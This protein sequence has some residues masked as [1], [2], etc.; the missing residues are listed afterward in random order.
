MARAKIWMEEKY[1][2]YPIQTFPDGCREEILSAIIKIFRYMW[3]FCGRRLLVCHLTV[4]LPERFDENGTDIIRSALHSWRSA[5]KHRK[6]RG[7]YIWCREE[8]IASAHAR[9]H[10]HVFVIVAGKYIRSGY[11]ICNDLNRLL[12]NRTGEDSKKVHI[13]PPAEDGVR[14]GKKVSE[15][16]NNLEDAIH[17][18][19]Y[20]AK[21]ST[22][23]APY[24]QRTYDYSRGFRNH[25]A[26]IMSCS[27]QE[28]KLFD[29]LDVVIPEEDWDVWGPGNCDLE[30][31]LNFDPRTGGPFY[32]ELKETPSLA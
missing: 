27:S 30:K 19:S 7:E 13:N 23:S 25:P 4:F 17:W 22:K 20:L 8:G 28:E 1:Q 6:I 9:T 18:A 2:G 11:S 10:Y 32:P 26:A 31:E 16:L 29:D 3:D 24:R 14:W 5:K 12:S 21:V 15:K